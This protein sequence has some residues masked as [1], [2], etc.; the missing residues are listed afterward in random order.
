MLPNGIIIET[1]GQFETADRKKH[2]LI[3]EQFPDLDIRFV[4]SN[5]HAKIGKK[6]KTTYAMWCDRLGIPWAS[7]RIPEEW[8]SEK[9][10]AGRTAANKAALTS[11]DG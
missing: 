2:K 10:K 8:L 1:K 11:T 7:K 3:R 4:F 6:S 5:P 9:P